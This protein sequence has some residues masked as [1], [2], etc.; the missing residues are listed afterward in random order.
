M[1][2]KPTFTDDKPAVDRASLQDFLAA[3]Y[4]VQKHNDRL[5]AGQPPENGHS[6]ILKDILE[7]QEQLQ[8]PHFD[9]REK[10]AAALARPAPEAD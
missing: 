5:Q 2:V 6:Q 3:A 1:P 9:L 4:V 10:M 7:L 8:S